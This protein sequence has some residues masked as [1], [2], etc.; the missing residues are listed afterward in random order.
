MILNAISFDREGPHALF[1]SS[2]NNKFDTERLS[3]KMLTIYP[4]ISSLHLLLT[5]NPQST[6]ADFIQICLY[7]DPHCITL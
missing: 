1:A 4:F 3:C 5:L 2:V 6:S 7:P